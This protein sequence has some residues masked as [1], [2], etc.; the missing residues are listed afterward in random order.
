MVLNNGT[1]FQEASSTGVELQLNER[2]KTLNEEINAIFH[3]HDDYSLFIKEAVMPIIKAFETALNRNLLLEDEKDTLYFAF[4]TRE[5][6]K[7][8]IR[9]R[10][11]AYKIAHDTGFV[12]NNEIRYL[13]DMDQIDGLD[14][15]SFN[16]AQVIY[17]TK[18]KQYY[19]P[20][21]G[22]T[23]NTLDEAVK[24]TKTKGGDEEDE[25]TN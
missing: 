22:A 1:K 15:I 21:T 18:T 13:E 2:K 20:N 25:N 24:S 9:A 14:T 16:L 11:E 3:I 6:T 4:D 17:D 5:I 7:G 10:Y 12:T 8:D 19:V 23:L